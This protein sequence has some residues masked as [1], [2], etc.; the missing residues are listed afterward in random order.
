M[1]V[2]E[3]SYLDEKKTPTRTPKQLELYNVGSF[4]LLAVTQKRK[5]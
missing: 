4:P 2:T 5:F 1:F 3:I